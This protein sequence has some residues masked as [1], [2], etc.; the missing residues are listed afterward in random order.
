MASYKDV[1]P[2]EPRCTF[3]DILI[4]DCIVILTDYMDYYT[5]FAFAL[6]CTRVDYALRRVVRNPYVYPPDAYAEVAFDAV[7]NG[8]LETIQVLY[9][10]IYFRLRIATPLG[11]IYALASSIGQ[12]QI[13]EFLAPK[14]KPYRRYFSMCPKGTIKLGQLTLDDNLRVVETL[15]CTPEEPKPEQVY[16]H[17]DGLRPA[18]GDDYGIFVLFRDD[19]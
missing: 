6:T 1:G 16:E 13:M 5:R 19:E 8:D 7:R 2:D 14:V 10:R 9:N 4:D 3:N 18:T 12:S 17:Y 15:T 11:H